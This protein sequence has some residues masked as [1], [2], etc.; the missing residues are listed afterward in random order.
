MNNIHIEFWQA[1][2]TWGGNYQLRGWIG[3]AY[4]HSK[5]LA[6]INFAKNTAIGVDGQHYT[7]GTPSGE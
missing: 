4:H 1:V 2:R 3:R 7:L 6:E 5:N